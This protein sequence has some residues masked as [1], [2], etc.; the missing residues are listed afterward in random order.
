MIALVCQNNKFLSQ[1]Y[2]YKGKI[3]L[4]IM[5]ILIIIDASFK[6]MPRLYFIVIEIIF[7]IKKKMF[8]FNNI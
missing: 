2:D 4:T 8:V 3:L 6:E 7:C 1:N 5:P